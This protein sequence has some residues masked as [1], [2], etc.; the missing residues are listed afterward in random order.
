MRVV[1]RRELNRALLARQ[2]LLERRAGSAQETIERL[3]GM[4]AQE[5]FDPYLRWPRGS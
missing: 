5:P 1:C 3:V 4:Q 2:E